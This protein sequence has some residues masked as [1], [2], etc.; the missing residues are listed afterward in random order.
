MSPR[1]HRIG[2]LVYCAIALAAAAPA[3]AG[4]VAV[5]VEPPFPLDRYAADGA[6]GLLVPGAGSTVTR[7]GA[8]A[9]LVRGRVESSLVGGTPG[10][11]AQIRLA[12]APGPVTIHV[13]L[14]PP[15]ASHNVVRYPIAIVGGG[16]RG[17]LRSSSTRIPG[18][19]SIADVAPTAKALEAGK[20]PRITS[21]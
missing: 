11:E 3:G 14:P 4:R 5:V 17:L 12:P 10:G 18:L 7:A 16:Y 21:R 2:L 9:S 13:S 1:R 20:P 6:V 19:V 8:L 15:G